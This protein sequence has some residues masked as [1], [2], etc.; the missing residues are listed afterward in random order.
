M[1]NNHETVI[2]IQNLNKSF[3]I[4]ED[5]KFSLRSLFSS[6][7]RQGK[8][9]VYE[10]L[11][12]INI[13]IKK[14]EFVG[15]LGRNGS[16]KSTLLKLIAGIYKP[17][18]GSRIEVKGRIVPFLELGVGFNPDLSGREN[19][20]LNG[21][22]LGMSRKD[23]NLKFDEIVRFAELEEFIETPVKN[24][25]SGMLVRLAFS[26]AIQAEADVYILDEILAVGDA[27]FQQKSADV[28]RE[29]KAKGKTII[30]VSHSMELINQY[31]DRVIWLN[32]GGVEFDG[33]KLQGINLYDNYIL[34]TERAN[35]SEEVRKTGSMDI[36]ISNFKITNILSKEVALSFDIINDKTDFTN[37]PFNITV[38]IYRSS[39]ENICSFSTITNPKQIKK[40]IIGISKYNVSFKHNLNHGKFYINIALFG[41]DEKKPYYWEKGLGS[42]QIDVTPDNLTYRGLFRLEHKWL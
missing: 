39:G 19:I 9:K 7:F 41:E 35:Q 6:F 33:G 29:L 42:F 8:T 21:T 32:K 16:G 17:E 24:Y 4:A 18:R 37:K 2:K 3:Y 31:C 12:Q 34:N 27:L 23:L 10:V 25:S 13:E 28:I 5:V 1:R 38:G 14:G 30:F 20:F 40:P 22:I 26:I 36:L 15:L 11:K